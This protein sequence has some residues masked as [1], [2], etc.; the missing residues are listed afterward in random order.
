MAQEQTALLS[1]ASQCWRTTARSR[2]GALLPKSL[3]HTLVPGEI[4]LCPPLGLF[5]QI[6]DFA[7][8][9]WDYAAAVHCDIPPLAVFDNGFDGAGLQAWEAFYNKQHPGFLLLRFLKMS[10][11][12]GKCD[13]WFVGKYSVKPTDEAMRKLIDS[14]SIPERKLLHDTCT[15]LLKGEDEK[16]AIVATKSNRFAKYLLSL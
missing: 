1:G 13:R 12:W 14:C 16:K 5:D 8:E 2:H 7:V 11:E 9:A 6:G 15:Y 10:S 3:W 4:P